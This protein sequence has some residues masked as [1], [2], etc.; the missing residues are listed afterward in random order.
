MSN[1]SILEKFK[2]NIHSPRA[3]II[4]G[5]IWHPPLASWVKCNTDGA[6]TAS[7]SACGGLFRNHNADFSYDGQWR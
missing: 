3:P 1:F 2:V 6:S 7:A 4:K 5:V